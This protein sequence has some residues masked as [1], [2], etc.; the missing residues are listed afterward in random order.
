LIA[1]SIEKYSY[2]TGTQNPDG[3]SVSLS[4]FPNPAADQVS[5]L[6]SIADARANNALLI[7]DMQ[8]KLIQSFSLGIGAGSHQRSFDVSGLPAGIYFV[9]LRSGKEN[10]VQKLVITK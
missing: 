3:K 9:T 10:A 2:P 8:G 4:V 5:M 7:T 6:Y 1:A